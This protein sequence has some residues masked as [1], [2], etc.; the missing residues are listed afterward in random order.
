MGRS[1][2]ITSRIIIIRFNEFYIMNFTIKYIHTIYMEYKAI[3]KP[4]IDKSKCK[5]QNTKYV[6]KRKKQKM[7][8]I[9][10]SQTRGASVRYII[11]IRNRILIMCT[12]VYYIHIYILYLMHLMHLFFLLLL[13]S[14]KYKNSRIYVRCTTKKFIISHCIHYIAVY[15]YVQMM[16]RQLLLNAL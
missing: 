6:P 15:I 10:R 14:Y 2:S 7:Q 9:M 5:L 4:I 3:Q 12:K 16:Y 8:R 1:F 11:I 13:L